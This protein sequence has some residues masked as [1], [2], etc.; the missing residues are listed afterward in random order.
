LSQLRRLRRVPAMGQAKSAPL[1]DVV[2]V[3]EGTLPETA[4]VTMDDQG[5]TVMAVVVAGGRR[6]QGR[7]AI[8][9][10]AA[11]A[12]A[13]ACHVNM[14]TPMATACR[15]N[16]ATAKA[17]RLNARIIQ[18]IAAMVVL[19]GDRT[20]SVRITVAV[21]AVPGSLRVG[22]LPAVVA[23]AVDSGIV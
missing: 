6:M 22:S 8:P 12:M 15:I 9:V 7:R 20:L 13:R 4:V 23:A 2:A 1:V 14:A 21:K 11:A 5:A 18:P 19:A 17:C 16:I 3:V 10:I